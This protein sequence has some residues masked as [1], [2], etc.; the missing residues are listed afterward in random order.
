[1]KTN[2]AIEQGA[3]DA[4][5]TPLGGSLLTVQDLAIRWQLT[6]ERTWRRVREA[7]GIKAINLGTPK[8]PELR[9]RLPSIEAWEARVE[10][11]AGALLKCEGIEG[12]DD[13]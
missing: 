2:T 3:P 10:Q 8:Y 6:I 9:F 11:R 12:A 7:T 13:Q 1:M 4:N 5:P